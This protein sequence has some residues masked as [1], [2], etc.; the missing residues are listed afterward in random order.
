MADK[1]TPLE[2]PPSYDASQPSPASN[3][4]SRPRLP[5][6]L[7]LPALNM[8]RGKRVILASAS[9]RRRQLLAQVSQLCIPE[10]RYDAEQ[11]ITAAMTDWPDR[12]RNH[13]FDSP[14]RQ[15]QVSHSFRICAGDRA[16][17]G[18]ECVSSRSGF[19]QR[20]TGVGDGSGHSC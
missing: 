7:E 20:G 1:K 17:K 16:A 2:P 15:K 12:P 11:Q 3:G 19:T 13:R 4:P 18:I 9:P 5:L 8:I 6:P 14:R 10:A